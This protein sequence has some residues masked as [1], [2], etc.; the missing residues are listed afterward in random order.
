MRALKATQNILSVLIFAAILF[1]LMG[2]Y[3]S[4]NVG[5][6]NRYIILQITYVTGTFGGSSVFRVSVGNGNE[7]AP[8]EI[9]VTFEDVKVNII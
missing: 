6:H 7:V 4:S 9:N 1:T 8:E 3:G 2:K 5:D